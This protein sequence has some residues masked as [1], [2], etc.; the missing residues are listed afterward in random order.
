MLLQ[1]N[2]RGFSLSLWG[3]RR[4]SSC[5]N[6][7][8]QD[9]RC[10]NMVFETNPLVNNMKADNAWLLSASLVISTA[11]VPFNSSPFCPFPSGMEW[12]YLIHY[13]FPPPTNPLLCV[14]FLVTDLT[15]IKNGCPDIAHLCF[16]QWRSRVWISVHRPVISATGNHYLLKKK[17]AFSSR[18]P[19]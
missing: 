8:H 2:V 18:H 16:I 12:G 6:I 15:E 11:R 14:P 10:G 1:Q 19:G 3:P 4:E 17:V 9:L 5:F 7:A 13:P